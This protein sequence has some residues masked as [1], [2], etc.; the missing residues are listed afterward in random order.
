LEI[1]IVTTLPAV[2]SDL[3]TMFIKMFRMQLS[4]IFWLINKWMWLLSIAF[5]F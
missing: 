4:A 3:C 5:S 1:I 2:F